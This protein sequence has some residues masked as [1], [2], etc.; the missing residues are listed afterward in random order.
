MVCESASEDSNLLPTEEHFDKDKC[1]ED[2]IE[3]YN[4]ILK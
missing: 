2:Y 3:L 4:R 1:F